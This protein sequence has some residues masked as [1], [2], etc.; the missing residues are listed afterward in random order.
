[1][2]NLSR[3]IVLISVDKLKHIEGFGKKR[4]IWLKNKILE[5]GVWTVPLKISDEHFLVMDG[6]H[7]MEAAKI[8][9]L[10]YVPCLVYSYDEVKVWSLRKNQIVTSDL[11]I[12][13]SL[14]GSIYPYKTAKHEFPDGG[15]IVCNY[16]LDLLRHEK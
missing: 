3:E 8:L 11:I 2:I 5:E 1:M 4:I 9:E 13:N 14:S 15:D 10:K 6:N 7:R 12:K 16:S